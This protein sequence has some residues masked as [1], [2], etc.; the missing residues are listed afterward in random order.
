MIA[1]KKL[2]LKKYKKEGPRLKVHDWKEFL[3]TRQKTAVVSFWT[4]SI[5]YTV[6]PKHVYPLEH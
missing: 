6:R 4:V 5:L 1:E 3:E 2:S